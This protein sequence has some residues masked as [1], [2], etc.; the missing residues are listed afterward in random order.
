MET[1]LMRGELRQRSERSSQ[2]EMREHERLPFS[3]QEY[4]RRYDVVMQ[5][6]RRLGLD[7]LLVRS[8]ENI[9]YLT[10]YETVAN[11]KYHCLLLS[12]DEP[13]LILRRYEEHNVTESSWLMRRVTVEDHE[14]PVQIAVRT[15]VAPRSRAKA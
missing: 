3:P 6:M 2:V 15:M 4:R 13:I 9:Y 7:A 14:H 8:P 11:H 1:P 10:G 5:S 12:H